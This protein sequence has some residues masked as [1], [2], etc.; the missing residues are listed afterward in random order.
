MHRFP[1]PLPS[2]GQK[3]PY[4]AADEPVASVAPSAMPVDIA[5]PETARPR[6]RATFAAPTATLARA[7]RA[8]AAEAAVARGAERAGVTKRAEVRVRWA[9]PRSAGGGGA[10]ERAPLLPPLCSAASLG[11]WISKAFHARE[12]VVV[13]CQPGRCIA[14]PR[15][16][17]RTCRA[18]PPSACAAPRR[19][20]AQDAHGD[21]RVPPRTAATARRAGRAVG[22]GRCEPSR[23]EREHCG[24]C[25]G[26]GH[27]V[28]RI[29]NP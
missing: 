13:A 19:T 16:S 6:K 21:R 5:A 1:P 12:R 25:T 10:A 11:R 9:A 28:Q 14:R 15:R 8:P 20:G 24:R 26:R 7:G 23:A 4:P 18:T 17:R 27:E 22:G 29:I 3:R 2:R